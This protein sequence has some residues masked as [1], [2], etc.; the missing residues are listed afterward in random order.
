MLGNA[1][2]LKQ[3]LRVR[4]FAKPPLGKLPKGMAKEIIGRRNESLKILK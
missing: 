4:K 3:K 1:K 2:E